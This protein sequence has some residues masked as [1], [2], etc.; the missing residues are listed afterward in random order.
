MNTGALP[1]TYLELTEACLKL[2]RRRKQ[3]RFLIVSIL[4]A[5]DATVH[6]CLQCG[7]LMKKTDP[8][9]LHCSRPCAQRHRRFNEQLVNFA[10]Q[11]P[12]WR[13]QD[14]PTEHVRGEE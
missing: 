11:W 7:K 14:Q 4:R 3:H 9:I 2:W 5:V 12:P 1:I 13:D 8:R 10:R 6:E